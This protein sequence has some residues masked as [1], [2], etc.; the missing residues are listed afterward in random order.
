MIMRNKTLAIFAIGSLLA[1][2]GTTFAGDMMKK[3]A[4]NDGKMMTEEKADTM[5]KDGMVKKEAMMKETMA[6]ENMMNMESMGDGK[7]DKKM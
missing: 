4:M 5:A 1:F 6:K 7:M 3:K 2:S